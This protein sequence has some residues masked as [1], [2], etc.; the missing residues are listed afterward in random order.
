[1]NISKLVKAS[2]II[3]IVSVAML[4]YWVFAFT[5]TQ[6]FGLKVFRQYITEMFGMSVL[7]V[8]ALMAGALMLNIMLNLTRIAE[9]GQEVPLTDM[10]KWLYAFVL[11]FPLLAAVLFGGNYLTVQQKQKILINSAEQLMK[12]HPMQTL[13]VLDYRFTAD[14]LRQTAEYLEILQKQNSAFR[15]ISVIVPDKVQDTPVYLSFDSTAVA[16]KLQATVSEKPDVDSII[17]EAFRK[18]DYVF[19]TDLQ[20]REY[21]NRIF[22]QNQTDIRF[23]SKD[24]NYELFYPYQH[25]G[26]TVAVFR[27]SDYQPYGKMGRY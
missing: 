6:V 18:A 22:Q 25:N 24:G 19:S 12:E 14:Y 20:G 2:N 27:L 17:Q 15:S 10:K 5:L 3:G 26:R 9:R 4:V 21:L 13:A 11:L 16:G 1:M 7:G 8:I 23:E